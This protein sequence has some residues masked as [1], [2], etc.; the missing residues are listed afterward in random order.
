M[1][2][3]VV[4][5]IGPV[6]QSIWESTSGYTSTPCLGPG[7]IEV[8]AAQRLFLQTWETNFSGLPK[9]QARGSP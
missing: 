6:I 4:T 5:P 1:G 7:R 9:A 8:I 3:H 2:L